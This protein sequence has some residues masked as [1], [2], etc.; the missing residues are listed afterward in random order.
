MWKSRLDA[1][2]P[3]FQQLKDQGIGVMFRPHH[4][5]NQGAFWWGGIEGSSGTA[6]LYRV[7]HDYLTNVKGLDNIVWVWS[8]QD[9][10]LNFAAYNPG[11]AYWDVMSLDVYDGRGFTDDKYAAML[12]IAGNKPIAI[13]ETDVLPTE[14]QLASQPR[15]VFFM[16]WAELVE[17]RNSR[18]AISAV[19]A[20]SNVLTRDELPAN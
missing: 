17:Q 6:A 14:S 2:A 9:L 7:T 10:N 19:Y 13:G 4:E 5:M 18:D 11:D 3:F 15:W 16:G 12:A 20:A 1:I 8:V